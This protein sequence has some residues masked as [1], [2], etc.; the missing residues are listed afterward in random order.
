MNKGDAGQMLKAF[1]YVGAIGLTMA[2]TIAVGLFGGRWL[3]SYLET[4]PYATVVGIILGMLAGLWSAYKRI[5]KHK[6]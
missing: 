2:A 3:D 1:S 6:E 5:M 4:T